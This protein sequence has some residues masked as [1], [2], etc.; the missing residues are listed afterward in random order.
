MLIS[1]VNLW[2]L[3]LHLSIYYEDVDIYFFPRMRNC[4]PHV[5]GWN[6]TSVFSWSY[7]H[8]SRPWISSQQI[9]SLMV[10]NLSLFSLNHLFGCWSYLKFMN[11]EMV[12]VSWILTFS[13]YFYY[14]T[15]WF[16][17]A[18]NLKG[19]DMRYKIILYFHLSN[20]YF[21]IYYRRLFYYYFHLSLF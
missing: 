12:F 10:N 7:S 2:F 21:K 14:Y 5:G 6:V 8:F 16:F 18:S 20:C 19:I 17:E 9:V 1:W 4:R 13:L 11:S 15:C 3:I